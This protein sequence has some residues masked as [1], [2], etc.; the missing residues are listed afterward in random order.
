VIARWHPTKDL[1]RR[2]LT[3][4][5]RRGGGCETETVTQHTRHRCRKQGADGTQDTH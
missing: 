4:D 5:D 2:L 1:R 3:G